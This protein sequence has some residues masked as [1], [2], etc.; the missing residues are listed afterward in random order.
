MG[1]VPSLAALAGSVLVF[2]RRLAL[3]LALIPASIFFVLFMGSQQRFFG[4]W[5]MPVFPIAAMLAAYAGVELVRALHRGPAGALVLGGPV[6]ALLL[7]SQSVAA[8]STTTRCS[9][10]LTR[11]TSARKL[12]GRAHPRGLEGRDRAGRPRQL[13]HP[14][15]PVAA[16]TC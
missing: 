2:P 5:L 11:A 8:S 10:G 1:W 14:T 6:A 16:R 3:A 9:R 12:D 13:G 7:L 15:R 4:R